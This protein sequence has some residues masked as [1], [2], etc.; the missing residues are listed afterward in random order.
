MKRYERRI[1]A[2]MQAIEEQVE[3]IADAVRNAVLRAVEALEKDDKDALYQVVLGDLPIN[4]RVRETDAMCH[5]FVARHLPAAGPLREVSSVLRLNIALERIGDYAVTIGRIGVKL[6]HPPAPALLS[7]IRQMGDL[8]VGMLEKATRAFLT[9]NVA[10]AEDTKARAQRVDEL[11]Y[12]VF[13]RLVGGEATQ[14]LPALVSELNIVRQLERVSDQSKNICEEAIFAASGQTK[15]PKVYK[16]LFVD[17]TNALWSQLARALAAKAFP[18]SGRFFSA[19]TAPASHIDPVL[20][21]L[22][23][24]LSLDLSGVRTQRLAPLKLS[25]AEYHVIVAL[26]DV[27]DLPEIPFKTVLLRW[28]APTEASASEA[29]RE[30]G[31]AVRD[32][33]E[34]L[35]GED[36]S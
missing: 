17:Q 25:P 32:L 31:A 1:S 35:R 11:H 27:P 24:E 29:A 3:W 8:S 26:G 5:A 34:A 20:T 14:G 16:V 19:G 22:A 10:L 21:E 12:M 30:L 18:N 6:E 23:G 7:E 33:M 28:A 4:R 36:A 9:K 2:D 13:Q 15:P